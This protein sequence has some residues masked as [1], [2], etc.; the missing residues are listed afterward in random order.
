MMVAIG[1]RGGGGLLDKETV[2]VADAVFPRPGPEFAHRH[3][4][5]A[6][7]ALGVNR[8]R[9]RP[10]GFGMDF[11]AVPVR[12][13]AEKMVVIVNGQFAQRFAEIEQKPVALVAAVDDAPGEHRQPRNKIVA[14]ALAK[15]RAQR[16]RPVDSFDLPTVGVEIFQRFARE[17]PGVGNERLD[18]GVPIALKRAGVVNINRIRICDAPGARCQPS[19]AVE[20]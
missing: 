20:T 8:H 14:V 17:R 9:V 13:V 5:P 15:F 10:A 3:V 18:H 2:F 12:V 6:E 4:V 11:Q 16:R 1:V 19:L 7:V